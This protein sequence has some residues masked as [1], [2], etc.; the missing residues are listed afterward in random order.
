MCRYCCSPV[1]VCEVAHRAVRDWLTADAGEVAGALDC[2][3][4][5]KV[6]EESYIMMRLG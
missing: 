2:T 1:S 5:E 4:V 3:S 6:G